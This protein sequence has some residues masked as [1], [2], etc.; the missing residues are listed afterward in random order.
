M[1]HRLATTDDLQTLA[2]WNHQL[3]QDE[4]HRNPMDIQQLKER[5][6]RWITDGGY[7]AVVFEDNG[8]AVAYALYREDA[9]EVC[10]RHLFVMRHLRR[11][12]IGRRAVKVLMSQLWP[13]TKRLTVEV[14]TEN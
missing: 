14:L 6:R 5:M 12:G 2:E 10:L 3:I 9:N 7:T 8:E 11:K 4:G 1:N 13:K